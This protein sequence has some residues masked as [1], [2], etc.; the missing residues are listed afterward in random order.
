M[1]VPGHAQRA[2][3]VFLAIRFATQS[4]SLLNPE[5]SIMVSSSSQIKQAI[6]SEFGAYLGKFVWIAV[7]FSL[8]LLI[9]NIGYTGQ[10]Y[11]VDATN[12]NDSNPGTSET[13]PWQTIAKVSEL[14]Y[15]PGEA[16]LLKRGEVWAEHLD[17]GED[18]DGDASHP[19][20]FGAYGNGKRPIIRRLTARGDYAIF[21]NLVI[22]HNKEAG[23]ALRLRG[24]KNCI[25]RNLIVRN[26]LADGIDVADA[27]GLLIDSCLVHHFLAGSFT[28]QADA[29]GI[30]AT[31]TQGLTIRNTEVHHVSGDSFQADPNRNDPCDDIL[32]ADCYFWTNPLSEDFNERWFAGQTPGENAIDTKVSKTEWKSARRMRITIRNIRAHGWIN[33]GFIGNRAAF[34]MKEKIEASFDGVTVYDCHVAFRLR[35]TLGNANVTL[36]NAVIYDCEKAIRAENKLSDLRIYNSTFGDGIGTQF[37]IVAGDNSD[38][39][40]IRNN[41]FI[42]VKHPAASANSN[43]V[44][45]AGDFVDSSKRNYHLKHGSG[46]IDAGVT[47]PLVI[48]D[49][50]GR[51][52]PQNS[53]YDVGSYECDDC[54]MQDIQE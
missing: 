10:T 42:N 31:D 52:R 5:D 50:D 47:I 19:I 34:N 9:S 1:L 38:T 44:A 18:F 35:G 17:V 29:H 12:G 16:V 15:K 43:K 14:T 49:R 4:R 23:D 51:G 24:A 2:P 21:E 32:I 45:T 39:W 20:T 36:I 53:G 33:D 8:F 11:Y 7:W 6:H 28:Q 30:V 26:G 37:Q 22:D 40:D 3:T 41:A 13:A 27:D 48:T 54:E 25:L 46:L